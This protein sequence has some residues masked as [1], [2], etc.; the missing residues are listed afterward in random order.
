MPHLTMYRIDQA[1]QGH[2]V[3]D[4][5]EGSRQDC[6]PFKEGAGFRTQ[7][8][9]LQGKYRKLADSATVPYFHLVASVA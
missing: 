8:W 2:R 5:R 7:W 4:I 9:L 6:A 3:Q 1:V